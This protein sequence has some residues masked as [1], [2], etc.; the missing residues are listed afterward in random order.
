V[1]RGERNE[2]KE[3]NQ[4][5]II[6]RHRHNSLMNNPYAALEVEDVPDVE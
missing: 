5:D 4:N 6:Y 1:D 2:V 3:R